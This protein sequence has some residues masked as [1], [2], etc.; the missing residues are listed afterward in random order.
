MRWSMTLRRGGGEAGRDGCPCLPDRLP[1]Q[2]GELRLFWSVYW[3]VVA[4]LPEFSGADTSPC[5]GCFMLVRQ[6][7]SQLLHP[8]RLL[9]ILSDSV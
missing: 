3:L 2:V 4:L 8:G 9:V 7:P 1:A 6:V 5:S